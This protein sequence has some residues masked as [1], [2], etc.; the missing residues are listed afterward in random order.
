[1]EES[2]SCRHQRG[3]PV[4]LKLRTVSHPPRLQRVLAEAGVPAMVRS[5]GICLA[6]GRHVLLPTQGIVSDLNG[7]AQSSGINILAGRNENGPDKPLNCAWTITPSKIPSNAHFVISSI[8]GGHIPANRIKA[9]WEFVPQERARE[10]RGIC[11]A[12]RFLCSIP[13]AEGSGGSGSAA[14]VRVVALEMRVPCTC[15]TGSR[16]RVLRRVA[17]RC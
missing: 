10:L 14:L 5:G 16:L 4:T 11:K 9:A 2:S 12:L 17:S 8:P 1:V 3:R 6:Q 15:R 7:A 13:E